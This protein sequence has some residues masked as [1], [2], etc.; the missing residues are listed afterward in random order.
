MGK[1]DMY[2]LSP[3]ARGTLWCCAFSLLVVR[4][5]PAGAGNTTQ[6]TLRPRC[7]P[8]YPRWR[9]EHTVALGASISWPGLSPLARGTQNHCYP[10]NRYFRFIPAGAGNTLFNLTT[11]PTRPV[12][13]RW[14]G[15]HEDYYTQYSDGGG[16]SPLARGTLTLN[17]HQIVKYRFIPAGAGNT[18]TSS[19][20]STKSA[21]YPRWRGEHLFTDS[22]K[23]PVNGLSPL[24]RGTRDFII[25]PSTLVRF[26]PAGAGN[27]GA[28]HS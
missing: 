20:T 11:R 25:P 3:L 22:Q 27:T 8:V 15:E 24:A 28:S 26:I 12:Y 1:F 4:F 9:G 16:L 19:I 14:R 2:G 17:P 13:P 10:E 7:K 18:L 23:S 5:I 21:V 6:E